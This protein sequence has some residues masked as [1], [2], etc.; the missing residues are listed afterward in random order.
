VNG[1]NTGRNKKKANVSLK[2]QE[3]AK[4]VS[5]PLRWCVFQGINDSRRHI[6]SRDG[7]NK[8]ISHYHEAMMH[9]GLSLIGWLF[10]VRPC[11]PWFFMILRTRKSWQDLCIISPD[12]ET[13]KKHIQRDLSSDTVLARNHMPESIINPS[14]SGKEHPR[15]FLSQKG[16]LKEKRKLPTRLFLTATDIISWSYSSWGHHHS[17]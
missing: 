4:I 15:V 1:R 13:L 11:N 7:P 8:S 2:T 3:Q 14:S 17:H 9:Q 16:T 12:R 10:K 5:S 6:S